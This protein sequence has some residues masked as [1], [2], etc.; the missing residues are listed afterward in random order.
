[1]KCARGA[2][3]SKNAACLHRDNGKMYCPRCA[4]NIN[5]ACP[6]ED[7]EPLVYFPAVK[8][9]KAV[10]SSL[11]VLSDFPVKIRTGEHVGKQAIIDKVSL[12]VLTGALEFNAILGKEDDYKR[13]ILQYTDITDGD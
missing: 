8:M 2:C 1:M 12:N 10:E 9:K 3:D 7:G 4:R 5:E 6:M 11:R 13:I